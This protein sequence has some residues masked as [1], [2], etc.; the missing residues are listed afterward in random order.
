VAN[1]WRVTVTVRDVS[2]V[3]P[4]L[5]AV[6]EHEVEDDARGRLGRRVAVSAQGSSIYFYAG[7]ENA[8]READAIARDLIARH[9]LS[10]DFALDR[11]HPAEEEWESADVAIPRTDEERAAEHRHLEE[12]ET[13]ESLST[14]HARWEV[15]VQL[16]AHRA[17]VELADRLRAEGHPVIRR[18]TLLVLGA[19]DEDDANALAQVVKQVA[20]AGA[21]VETEEIGPLL[22]FTRIGPIPIW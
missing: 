1:D 16:P 4:A 11:W 20:P 2:H 9:G 19:N 21:T 18:W 7:T 6:R 17:A 8:A 14:G 15:R 13:R 5:R 10:A 22:P 3:E 12:E